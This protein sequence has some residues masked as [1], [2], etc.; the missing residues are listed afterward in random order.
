MPVDL[1]AI[2]EPSTTAVVTSEIQNGVIGP[3]SSLPE[4]A[5]NA[6]A[7]LPNIARLVEGG[8]AAGARI[9]HCTAIRRPDGQGT[10]ANARLFQYMGKA[11]N[12]LHPGSDAS[13]IVPQVKLAESDIVLERLHGISP[14]HGTELD[15]VL[16]NLGVVTIVALG[17]S[18]NVAITNLAFD[19]VNASYQVVIPR[20]G[21]AGFPA[22]YAEAV[23]DNTLSAIATLVRTDEILSV[24]NA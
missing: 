13:R 4:L 2:L 8:R 9:I 10:N 21:V 6:Q 24:W 3:G 15:F 16:R 18:V 7:V 14:F 22:E 19:A 11:K 12:P 5:K 20:D 1:N 23:F 17:V